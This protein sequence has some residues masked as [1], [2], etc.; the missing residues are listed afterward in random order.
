MPLG[1]KIEPACCGP[2]LVSRPR[3]GPSIDTAAVRRWRGVVR[4]NVEARCPVSIVIAAWVAALLVFSSFFM[5][6]MIPLRVVA[7]TS[8]VAFI[9]YAL[10]GLNYGIFG[11]V[12]PILVLHSALLPLNIV[13]LRE[14]K[15][16]IKTVNQA[17]SSEAFD[18]LIPYMT[19][20]KHRKGETV[21]SKGNPA[22][23]LYMIGEGRVRIPE[24]GKQL[25]D[26]AVFGEV[27]LFA[28]QGVRSVSAVCDD[29]CRLYSIA[30][31][32]VLELY[33]QNPRFGFFLIRLVSGIVQQGPDRRRASAPA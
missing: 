25:S 31:D 11:R 14:I 1:R 13:R 5:K 6:T 29:D 20:E 15:R 22:D 32:R 9:G 21:F 33:Y 4:I 2:Y 7:I 26:G 27:G 8:N 10:L 18:S 30:K 28:P 3:H 12:Y 16:L 17:S 19:S 23:K 24:L